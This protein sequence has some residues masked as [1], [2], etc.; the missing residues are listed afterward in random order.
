MSTRI[1]TSNA[2]SWNLAGS[3][4]RA[5]AAFILTVFLARHLTPTAFG[6]VALAMPFIAF[7]NIVIDAGFGSALIQKKHIIETDVQ[8]IFT[9]QVLIGISLTLLLLLGAP[10]IS[11]LTRQPAVLDVLRALAPL[12]LFQALTQT[13]ISLLKR[14]LR[15]KDIQIAQ[16]TSYLVGYGVIGG[17]LAFLGAGVWSLVAANVGQAFLFM[18]QTYTLTRHPIRPHFQF[19][20]DL[21][22]FGI[23]VL[24]TN[25]VNLIVA[26]LD[27]ILI[28]RIF[29]PAT[30]GLYDRAFYLSS[31][32]TN[33]FIGAA[34]GIIFSA[35]SRNQANIEYPRRMYSAFFSFV[36]AIFF[37][38]FFTM[39]ILA[40][41]L[42]AVIYGQRWIEASFLLSILCLVMP[43]HALMALAGPVALGLGRAELELKVQLAVLV[44]AAIT[45]PIAAHFSLTALAFAIAAMYV[46]RFFLMTVATARLLAAPILYLVGRIL[47]SSVFAFVVAALAHIIFQ[48]TLTVLPTILGVAIA[49]VAAALVT[50]AGLHF[51]PHLLV[52]TA[53]TQTLHAANHPFSKLL[54]QRRI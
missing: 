41:P 29:G 36:C 39:A 13:S 7:G 6:L 42:L 52:G 14:E 23:K 34:Q 21:S 16:I 10:F 54:K 27:R 35:T 5:G 37:P 17:L 24:A 18:I 51:T 32:P 31:T 28:G 8:M 11:V 9:L 4:F 12:F 40:T 20:S 25:I 38:L 50:M 46:F 26:T 22:I 33:V 43:F 45:F 47:I 30:L 15:F 1:T 48:A 49:L 2:F 3:V 53:A 44:F 19:Q